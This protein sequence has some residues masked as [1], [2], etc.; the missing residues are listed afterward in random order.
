MLHRHEP[1]DHT[2]PLLLPPAHRPIPL[3]D[4][5][6]W[7]RDVVPG[8]PELLS[9]RAVK[10]VAQHVIG[11]AEP[12]EA[13]GHDLRLEP[14]DDGRGVGPRWQ[15]RVDVAEALRVG[16]ADGRREG[17][18]EIPAHVAIYGLGEPAGHALLGLGAEA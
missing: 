5:P 1:G 18:G 11:G 8:C 17:L 10:D 15:P 9:R 7:G 16:P 13:R 12:G 3:A 6:L 14:G 4:L 2:G